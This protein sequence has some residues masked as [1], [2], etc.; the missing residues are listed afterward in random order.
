[1]L[2]RDKPAFQIGDHVYFQNKQP[3][4]SDLKMETWIQKCLHRVQETFHLH[5]E[6]GHR[7]YMILHCHRHHPRTL[8][9]VSGILILSLAELAAILII[10]LI[11]QLYSLQI[12][13]EQYKNKKNQKNT[14]KTLHYCTIFNH[15]TS[16]L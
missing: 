7:K 9:G 4:K 8:S 6:P 12:P 2:A 3:G 15:H 16:T 1:M 14:P 11:C 10:L 13:P 5:R